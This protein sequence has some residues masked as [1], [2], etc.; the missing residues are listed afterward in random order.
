MA[1]PAGELLL[2]LHRTENE[3]EELGRIHEQLPG[4]VE[5]VLAKAQAARDL[6][7]AE[8]SKLER[9]E[10]TRRQKEAELADCEARRDKYQGQTSL[11]K[12]NVEYTALLTEID[13]MT[14]RISEVEEEILA[15]M[16][17]VDEISSKLDTFAGEKKREEDGFIRESE[18]LR[19]RQSEVASGLEAHEKVRSQLLVELPREV[20]G[21]YE[22]LRASLGTG[23]AAVEGRACSACHRD[24]PYETI[25]R[26][27]AGE[28]HGCAYCQRLLVVPAE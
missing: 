26:L 15:A 7:E 5:A 9:A 28:I 12:T 24:I 13:G 17:E 27:T 14:Q 1:E 4:L 16:E 8:R 21:V 11:V 22:R 2:S 20:Q 19:K 23:T 10:H 25:N 18:E 3:L 6:V